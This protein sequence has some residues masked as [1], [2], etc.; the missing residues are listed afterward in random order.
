MILEEN[1]CG[2]QNY[3][4]CTCNAESQ[5]FEYTGGGT[6]PMRKG[7]RGDH[8]KALQVALNTKFNTPATLRIITPTDYWG[9]KTEALMR[10]HNLP[11]EIPNAQVL[12][13]ILK[14]KIPNVSNVST[15]SSNTNTTSA[16]TWKDSLKDPNKALGL[17]G[18]IST[19]ASNFRQNQ[20]Q[21]N[22][23]FE[24]RLGQQDFGSGGLQAGGGFQQATNNQQQKRLPTA[25]WIAI[26]LVGLLLIGFL[27]FKLAK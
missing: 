18:Q 9:Y 23:D 8:V 1:F 22:Q 27:V 21:R 3:G 17:L 12:Q 5:F 20:N 26:A 15:A 11:L 19:I 4:G 24:F 13:Q 7:I 14:G 16:N 25:A 6:F 10:Y 2:C